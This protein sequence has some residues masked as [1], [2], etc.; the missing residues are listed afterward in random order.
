[1]KLRLMR[2]LFIAGI[3]VFA[4]LCL[5][6]S[7]RV[8]EAQSPIIT[9]KS[10]FDVNIRA[11]PG[12]NSGVIGVLPGGQEITA[13]GR[14]PGNNWTQIEYGTTTGW[15]AAWLLVFSDD[16]AALPV[17]TDDQPPAVGSAPFGAVS[18]YNVN[19]RTEP[20]VGSTILQVLPYN[21]EA[22]ATGRTESSS[23][24]RIHYKDTEGWVAAWLMIL[25]GDT[26]ALPV[27]GGAALPTETPVPRTP[28]VPLPPAPTT[29]V[30]VEAP[31]NVNIRSAPNVNGAVLGVIPYGM[32]TAAI[33]RNAGNNW[34]QIERD[35]TRGWVASWVVITSDDTLQLPITSDSADVAAFSGTITGKGVY[36]VVIR[37]GPGIS[38]GNQGILPA[39]TGIPLLARTENSDWIKIGFEGRE[40]WVAAWLIVAN[41]DPNNLPIEHTT[42]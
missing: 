37:T 38:F 1:M 5:A 29:G 26:N 20:Q 42:P 2:N 36:D 19:I 12:L 14:S 11:T 9:G 27:A 35:G 21:T 24:V 8:A 7:T 41:A 15:V 4:S 30:T 39:H 13:L 6:I 33:G 40:G 10:I 31:F 17:T 16:T 32:T 22:T 34:I 28:A 3:V 18:P 23:W 25:R